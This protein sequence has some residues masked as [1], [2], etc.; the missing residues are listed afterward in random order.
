MVISKKELKARVTDPIPTTEMTT[1]EDDHN[2]NRMAGPKDNP[3]MPV[4]QKYQLMIIKELKS[5]REIIEE[6]KERL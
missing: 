2:Q 4:E 6:I 5:I 3:L 1:S